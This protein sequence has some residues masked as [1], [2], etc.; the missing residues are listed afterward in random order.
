MVGTLDHSLTYDHCRVHF[1]VS[2][3]S[4]WLITSEGIHFTPS[5]VLL[6]ICRPT[7]NINTNLTQVQNVGN[8][9][10]S[11]PLKNF[12]SSLSG[13]FPSGNAGNLVGNRMFYSND[14]MVCTTVV[15]SVYPQLTACAV[16]SPRYQ[17]RHD[18]QDVLI[19][20]KEH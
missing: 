18:A 7:T 8:L 15:C 17:L 12:A 1:P 6:T 3:L 5:Y 10:S 19:P 11:T 16:G 14:Y 20:H 2:S 13:S 9:W 4:L